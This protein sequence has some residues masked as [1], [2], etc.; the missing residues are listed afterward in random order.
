MAYRDTCDACVARKTAD[1]AKVAAEKVKPVELTPSRGWAGFG[2]RALVVLGVAVGLGTSGG[3]MFAPPP[4][5]IIAFTFQVLCCI[6]G[7]TVRFVPD[8][9]SW[10][11][12][13]P[14]WK[15]ALLGAWAP[16]AV[17]VLAA[18]RL[19]TWLVTGK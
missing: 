9:K 1:E 17:P 11:G 6:I 8:S 18:R 12:Q 15:V 5:G 14:W 3:L 13:L 16:V 4:I 7:A 10:F 2:V 19:W